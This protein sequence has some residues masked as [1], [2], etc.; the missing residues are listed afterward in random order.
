MRAALDTGYRHIDTAQMYFN[1]RGVGEGIRASGLGRTPAQV[2]LR[3]HIQKG[4][5]VFPKTV[6]PQ[7]MRENL[8]V[9]DFVLD[10]A[11][12]AAIDGLDKGIAGRLGPDPNE[13]N[14]IPE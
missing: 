7:R 4:T 5:V 1:E 2:V 12:M 14:W 8:S 13:F 10:D 3:W 9:F 11:A 6:S